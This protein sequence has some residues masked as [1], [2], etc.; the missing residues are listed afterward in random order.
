M[1]ALLKK[2]NETFPD[3]INISFINNI[4]I[5]TEGKDAEEVAKLLEEARSQLV[6]LGKEHHISFD[7]EKTEATLFTWKQK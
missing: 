7:E 1:H 6:Y 2:I 4:S 3:R 5:I